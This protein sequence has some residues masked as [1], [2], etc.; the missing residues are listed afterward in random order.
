M[1]Y[2][3]PRWLSGT[4]DLLLRAEP[5]NQPLRAGLVAA[6]QDQPL[7]IW[8]LLVDEPLMRLLVPI[9][10][11]LLSAC[12]SVPPLPAWQSPEGLGHPELGQIIDLRSDNRLSAQQLINELAEIDQVLVGERHD[13]PDHHALQRWLVETLAQRREQGSLLLEMLNPDQQE[14]VSQTQDLIRRG[15]RPDD[16][17]DA[18]KWQV[19]WDWQLYKSVVEYSLAQPFPV[20]SANLDRAEILN[21]YRLRP[22]M[23]GAP[24]AESVQQELLHQVRASHCNLLP[25]AQLPAMLAVQ[26]HRD[27]RMAERLQAAPTPAMLLAGAFHVRRDLGIPLH[28]AD[29][30]DPRTTR[31]LMLAEVGEVVQ[32]G[33]ADFVWFTPAQTPQDYCAGLREQLSESNRSEFGR[34]THRTKKDPARAG[35]KP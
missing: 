26:Q 3:R 22:K 17:P 33:Q 21:I 15:H 12:Q 5:L 31:V 16:L 1:F 29:R 24:A 11:V 2:R 35:S 20:L 10:M 23:T 7:S 4:R 27:R 32:A 19:G 34:W 6:E 28:L 13:N 25:E 18:L 8:I 14:K 30:G 9:V